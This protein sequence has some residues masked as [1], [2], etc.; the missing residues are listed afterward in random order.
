MQAVIQVNNHIPAVHN[1]LVAT[2]A[3][4]ETL[5]NNNGAAL[6]TS[7]THQMNIYFLE[8]YSTGVSLLRQSLDSRTASPISIA[9]S[10]V[11][12]V[13]IDHL[14]DRPEYATQ[15]LD[16]AMK[17]VDRRH[18]FGTV[19]A[20]FLNHYLR[21]TV[22]RLL[23]SFAGCANVFLGSGT[24]TWPDAS[25]GLPHRFDHLA[26]ASA[27]LCAIADYIFSTFPAGPDRIGKA[28]SLEV[29]SAGSRC[30][31]EWLSVFLSSFESHQLS[32][33]CYFRRDSL[34]LLIRQRTLNVLI[35]TYFDVNE[36]SFDSHLSDFRNVVSMCRDFMQAD[37][38]ILLS[39]QSAPTRFQFDT[40][41][42]PPLTFTGMRC[43]DP[44]IRR[45]ALQLLKKQDRRESHWGSDTSAK[46]VER[47]ILLEEAG[48]GIVST[49]CDV[50]SSSR[51]RVL[52]CSFEPGSVGV[53]Q[54]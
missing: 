37:E 18:A 51:I 14:R 47:L 17:L 27:S 36:M 31:R 42:I 25:I 15:H 7:Y 22:Q 2:G 16:I 43:R 5:N 13:F 3:L 49:A 9:V 35:G 53:S 26:E 19:Q 10:C 32:S 44:F 46:V 40:A 11:L 45:Q 28:P 24:S 23:F 41:I 34:A 30:L 12:L 50:P 33:D 52:R 29:T 39:S 38:S 1:L 20:D 21:P 6:W 8:N 4:C 48:L 54:V